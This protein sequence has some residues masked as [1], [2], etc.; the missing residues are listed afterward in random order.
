MK[1]APV[2]PAEWPKIICNGSV[3][4]KIYRVENKGCEIIPIPYN[5]RYK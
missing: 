1:N 3:L 4:V 2:K 5:N